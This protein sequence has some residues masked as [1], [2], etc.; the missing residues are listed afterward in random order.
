MAMTD[1]GNDLAWSTTNNGGDGGSLTARGLSIQTIL[2]SLLIGGRVD[3]SAGGWGA[4]ERGGLSTN[5]LISKLLSVL[6]LS[7]PL[8]RRPR[9][10]RARA[11]SVG[12]MHKLHHGG[13]GQGHPWWLLLEGHW[14]DS[15]SGRPH[16]KALVS[17]PERLRPESLGPLIQDMGSHT[18]PPPPHGLVAHTRCS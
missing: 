6:H 18:M 13:K 14:R 3:L 15:G 17:M 5:D 8:A 10:L 12:Q 2:G 7:P 1:S 11:F 16:A 4:G 9:Q